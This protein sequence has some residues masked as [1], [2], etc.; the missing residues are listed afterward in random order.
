LKG[1][2]H[3]IPADSTAEGGRPGMWYTVGDGRFRVMALASSH[4]PNFSTFFWRYTYADASDRE[5][6]TSLPRTARGWHLGEVYAYLIDVLDSSGRPAF[7]ILYQDAAAEPEFIVMPKLPAADQRG[8]DLA[9]ICAGNYQNATNY[10]GFLLGA[11]KP[12]RVI[13]SHWEDFFRTLYPPF[14][15]IFFNNVTDL[16]KSL[17]DHVPGQWVTPEPMAEM[18]YR[19]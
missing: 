10:P 5:P 14:K 3:A 17:R 4:A 13:V 2:V 16:A 15:G 19:Y 18:I 6:R 12:K 9:I 11:L 8:V 7:R 1:R